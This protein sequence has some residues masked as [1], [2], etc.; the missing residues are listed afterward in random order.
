MRGGWEENESERKKEKQAEQGNRRERE[1]VGERYGG[2]RDRWGEVRGRERQMG[3]GT[4][5]ERQRHIGGGGREGKGKKGKK[6]QDVKTT[7]E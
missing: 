7:A 4:G 2:E 1:T 5:G 6:L 3:R